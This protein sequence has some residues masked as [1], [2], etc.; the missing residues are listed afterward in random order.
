MEPAPQVDP[1][2]LDDGRAFLDAMA[3]TMRQRQ[4]V[5]FEALGRVWYALPPNGKRRDQR[6][7]YNARQLA[8]RG[9]LDADN[10]SA[11]AKAKRAAFIESLAESFRA[12]ALADRL[13][14]AA[15]RLL[16]QPGEESRLSALPGDAMVELHD[17]CM[18]ALGEG[19]PNPN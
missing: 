3:A 6:D 13:T 9:W 18:V 8:A 16:Y 14:D 10:L 5:A 1:L 7:L 2:A 12:L 17:A 15:G 4:P 19:Q 11:D